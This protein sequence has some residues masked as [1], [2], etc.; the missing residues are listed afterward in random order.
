MA[1]GHATSIFEYL[2]AKNPDLI[3]KEEKNAI[4][5]KCRTW[6]RPRYVRPWQEF[7]FET[8]ERVFDGKLM[9]ECRRDR[10]LPYPVP[11]LNPEFD[12]IENGEPSTVNILLR[13]TRPMVITALQEVVGTF[14]PIFW[15]PRKTDVDSSAS[16]AVLIH[17]PSAAG[18]E[19]ARKG[20]LRQRKQPRP[21][22]SKNRPLPPRPD[23]AGISLRC[24]GNSSTNRLP[25]EIKPGSK[26]TSEKL[27]AG[28]LTNEDGEFSRVKNHMRPIVQIYHYCVTA[29]ARYGFLITSKEILVIRIKPMSEGPGTGIA[30]AETEGDT[31]TLYQQLRYNG[32]VEYKA[33]PWGN[34]CSLIAGQVG[35]YQNLT[36]NLSLWILSILAGNNSDPGWN[37][38]PLD[39]EPLRGDQAA[40]AESNSD[41]DHSHETSTELADSAMSSFCFSEP[42]QSV[43]ASFSR[44][45]LSEKMQPPS[46]IIGKN[47]VDSTLETQIW[48]SS[49]S[50]RKRMRQLDDT[51]KAAAPEPRHI[52][53]GG[54]QWPIVKRNKP[55]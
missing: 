28:D 44:R 25:S 5:S 48:D 33:I 3:Y 53:D 45:D 8:M 34:H 2:T 38:Q 9:E 14:D 35:S 21:S 12:C 42:A 46:Y 32:L 49:S 40:A 51:P 31:T 23:G 41:N 29:K 52:I 6:I 24:R 50:S 37:Y 11:R 13:W 19:G 54:G 4:Q 16:D 27:A 47:F 36:V 43:T 30:T 1:N 17:N 15:V 39:K 26:W 18:T 20:H 10:W 55:M 22:S 7:S